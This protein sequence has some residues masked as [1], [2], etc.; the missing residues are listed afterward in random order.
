MPRAPF[1]VLV[2]P[3]RRAASGQFEF[4]LFRTADGYWQ[5]V[6]GGGEE[7]EA[8]FDAAQRELREEIGLHADEQRWVKLDATCSVPVHHFRDSPR[9]DDQIYVI[10]EH[11]FGVDAQG[12]TIVLSREHT[13]FKWMAFADAQAAAHYDSNRTALWELHQRLRGR[14]FCTQ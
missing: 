7:G 11:A 3:F 2:L 9:W 8:P 12:H 14:T 6:A 13:E 4:A 10:P 5:G 1:Q